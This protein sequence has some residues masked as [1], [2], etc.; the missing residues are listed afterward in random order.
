MTREEFIK[1][2]KEKRYPY[3]IEGD[4]IIVT[5]QGDVRLN[6]LTSLPPGVEFNNRGYVFL[7]SLTSLPPGV[8]FK[9]EMPVN[10][11]GLTSLPRGDRKSVE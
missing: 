6:S 10:L 7:Q 4:K 8:V 9:N 2:L 5:R 1:V 11:N 3:K